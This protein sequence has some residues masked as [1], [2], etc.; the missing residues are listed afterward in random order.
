MVHGQRSKSWEGSPQ[1]RKAKEKKI[2]VR[3]LHP[4]EDKR[5]VI[6]FRTGEEL[7]PVYDPEILILVFIETTRKTQEDETVGWFLTPI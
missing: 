4:L 5:I 1:T 3:F 7:H 6:I 2:H